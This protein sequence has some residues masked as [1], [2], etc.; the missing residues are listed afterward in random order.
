MAELNDLEKVQLQL[1]LK[2]LII[3]QAQAIYGPQLDTPCTYD[4]VISKAAGLYIARAIAY[5]EPN[6]R[7]YTVV[8][9]SSP[10]QSFS[11]AMRD[12]L[13]KLCEGLTE[14]SEGMDRS[15]VEKGRE[16]RGYDA[17]GGNPYGYGEGEE[18]Y[19]SR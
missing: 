17:Y 11:A 15:M 5:T 2:K 8:R 1:E 19:R 18:G 4:V 6:F 13:D 10:K 16:E 3:S 7:A 12:L 14:S 9:E